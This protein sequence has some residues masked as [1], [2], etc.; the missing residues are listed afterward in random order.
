MSSSTSSAN[1][2]PD[3]SVGGA[4]TEPATEPM[5][6]PPTGPM[7]EPLPQPEAPT[8][9]LESAE[10][11]RGPIPGGAPTEPLSA[12]GP[13]AAPLNAPPEP[14]APTSG[15]WSA[16]TAGATAATAGA[17]GHPGTAGAQSA[18]W[19]PARPSGPLPGAPEARRRASTGTIIWG[20]LLLALGALTVATGAGLRVD[21]QLATIGVL[22]LLGA[23]LLI[24]AIMPHRGRG[25]H[26]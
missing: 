22:G 8:E 20:A 1:D 4:P 11:P 18:A 19:T 13:A 3:P 6:E 9:S 16:T 14:G 26:P 24:V 5:T 21:L 15:V 2:R 17:P 10:A 23:A 25:D 12:A 7:T